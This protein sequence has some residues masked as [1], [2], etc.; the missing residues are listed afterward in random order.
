[1]GSV[2]GLEPKVVKESRTRFKDVFPFYL[3][4]LS[5]NVSAVHLEEGGEDGKVLQLVQGPAVGDKHPER[6]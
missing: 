2:L 3:G 6:E 1:M 4:W 5:L